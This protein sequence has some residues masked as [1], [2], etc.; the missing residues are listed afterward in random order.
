LYGPKNQRARNRHLRHPDSEIEMRKGGIEALQSVNN[1]PREIDTLLESA[2]GKVLRETRTQIQM[3]ASPYLYVAVLAA[4]FFAAPPA[5]SADRA[6][7]SQ[8]TAAARAVVLEPLPKWIETPAEPLET[9]RQDPVVVRLQETQVKVDKQVSQFFNRA[10]QVNERSALSS[11]GQF[12]LEYNPEYQKIHLHKVA[13]L[14]DGKLLDRSK[15]AQVRHL[16]RELGIESG[17]F[18]GT[19]TLVLLLRDVRIG[20]TLWVNYSIDGRNPVFGDTWNASYNW[21]FGAPVEL[22]RIVLQHPAQRQITWR[23]LGDYHRQPIAF[24][25]EERNGVRFLRFEE[26]ALEAIEYEPRVPVNFLPARMLEFSEYQQWKDIAGWAQ[27]LFPRSKPGPSLTALARQFSGEAD[28]AVRAAAALRWVQNE[29]RYF[30]VS[31]GE[32]SHRPHSPE[33]VLQLRYGD[34]KDK[35]YLLANLLI[36]LGI[37]AYPVLVSAQEP[38]LPGRSLPGTLW[39]D[40]AVVGLILDGKTYYVDPTLTGQVSQVSKLPAILPGAAALPVLASSTE[41][42]TLPDRPLAAPNYEQTDHIKITTLD[43]DATLEL[44]QIYRGRLADSMRVRIPAMSRREMAKD[45]LSLYEKKFR[46]IELTGDPVISDDAANNL[47]RVVSQFKISTPLNATKGKYNWPFTTQ[48]LVGVLPL[49]DK[50]VR[51]FP[52]AI[53]AD[54]PWSRFRTLL[55]WPD[56]VRADDVYSAQTVD[57]KFFQV[58]EE[59]SRRG[60]EVDYM[61]DYRVKKDTA[62]PG[63]MAELNTEARKMDSFAEGKFQVV[64][65]DLLPNASK[66]VPLRMIEAEGAVENLRSFF[67]DSKKRDAAMEREEDCDRLLAGL[68]LSTLAPGFAWKTYQGMQQRISL[69]SAS[70]PDRECQA[71]SQLRQGEFAQSLRTM[72]DLHAASGESEAARL[73]AWARLYTGD[74]AAAVSAMEAY[75]AP[76]LQ[77]SA[78][79]ENVLLQPDR[80]ALHQRAGVT[81]PDALLALARETPDGPWPRPVLAMQVGLLS[82]ERLLE[83]VTAAS[84]DIAG[85][86]LPQAWYYIGHQYAAQGKISEAVK[87]FQQ[88]ATLSFG[89][90]GLGDEARA[91]LLQLAPSAPREQRKRAF[92]YMSGEGVIQDLAQGTTLMA[93]AATAGD[94][95]AQYAYAWE[96][97]KKNDEAGFT[98]L[99]QASANQGY[100]PAQAEWGLLLSKRKVAD[101]VEARKWLELAAMQGN[102]A[103]QATLGY[104]YLEGFGVPKDYTASVFWSSLAARQGNSYGI[105]NLGVH[106]QNGYGVAANT[107]MAVKLY[108][109]AGELGNFSGLVKLGDMY[110]DGHGVAR[111]EARAVKLFSKAAAGNEPAAQRNLAFAYDNGRGVRKDAVE[112]HRLYLL[113]A[114]QGD[115]Q[116]Q[117]NVGYNYRYGEAV[118]TDYGQALK[119]FRAAAAQGNPSAC[120]SLGMAYRDGKGAK[121]DKIE[122]MKWFRLA[123]ERGNTLAANTIGLAYEDGMGVE[124]DASMA[125]KWY[126]TAEGKGNA[127]ARGN[128]ARLLAHGE[129]GPVDRIR[130]Y[131]LWQAVI[132][133]EGAD[134]DTV[135][136]AR[137]GLKALAPEMSESELSQAKGG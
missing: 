1:Y 53:P 12:T 87:A 126:E 10:V 99:L 36:A 134:A 15:D 74:A 102:S 93:A 47:L 25:V 19:E 8:S 54:T 26:R 136:H 14:R 41:L 123:H 5:F 97:R 124:A 17:T 103:A 82:P 85:I 30:S 64:E 39:F 96:L 108:E 22:R 80:L 91:A 42:V 135:A 109:A 75:A 88:A 73:G 7:E 89:A 112:A 48:I 130:A 127:D 2:L 32:N 115:A 16:Q 77:S 63:E 79:R 28:P 121:R 20:D 67:N 83:L 60:K 101:Q 24:K 133:D 56:V 94:E 113:A 70:D 46:S 3:R 132:A 31:I 23:Q 59:F 117:Y 120:H 90:A 57:N 55:T 122:A 4:N 72:K 119:W 50:L 76:Y 45:L 49:P 66:A 100:A 51:N 137:K 27:T 13:L 69:G 9:R 71:R 40:H 35:S 104:L 6:A 129:G 111:D 110:F 52:F 114:E 107:E 62:E 95:V 78:I 33:Q 116:A 84:P 61:L 34:C 105:V 106:F 128:L 68:R 92:A 86:A 21:D 44:H 65:R 125:R 38:K 98:Q 37:D 29:V 81:I 58:N 131:K 18:V 118:A 43:G 11:I